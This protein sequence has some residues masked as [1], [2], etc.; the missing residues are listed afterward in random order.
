MLPIIP[1][2]YCVHLEKDDLDNKT[3]VELNLFQ[4]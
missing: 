3:K 1:V 2:Y 4:V